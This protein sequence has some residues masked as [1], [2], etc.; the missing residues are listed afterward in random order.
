GGFRRRTVDNLLLMQGSL[1]F[2]SESLLGADQF[3]IGGPS[4][5]RG[6]SQNARFGD[7]GFRASV[8][9]RITLQRN[10]DGSPALQVAPYVDTA[11]IWNQGAETTDQ[12]FLLGT[13]VGLIANVVENLQAR[14]D[15]ALP[16]VK[17]NEASDSP[18][19]IFIYFS[20]DYRF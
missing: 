16:L 2:A 19:D 18:Q 1:Q 4:S 14:F 20:M 15:V 10:E 8:E 7:N 9:D 6:Y 12:P 17:I 11:M 3:I 5:V 13:G